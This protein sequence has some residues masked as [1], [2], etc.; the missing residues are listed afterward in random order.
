MAVTAIRNGYKLAAAADALD[1]ATVGDG[2]SA[3]FK[4]LV[5]Q[6]VFVAGGTSGAT[7]V[8]DGQSAQVV[9]SGTPTANA[10]TTFHYDPPQE[11]EDVTFTTKGTN[12]D[13]LVY[14]A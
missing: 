1:N 2:S 10:T 5:K 14:V 4:V 7:V 6:I 11:M 8:S 13:V 9:A 12:V 3:P